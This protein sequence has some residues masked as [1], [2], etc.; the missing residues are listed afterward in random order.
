MN[1]AKNERRNIGRKKLQELIKLTLSVAVGVIIG[2]AIS[3]C[4][5]KKTEKFAREEK[6]EIKTEEKVTE[7]KSKSQEEKE[8]S[9]V[10][11]LHKGEVQKEVF[12]KSAT[13][14]AYPE[15]PTCYD[16]GFQPTFITKPEKYWN[17]NY[18]EFVF[19]PG[20]TFSCKILDYSI[21]CPAISS[22]IFVE[23]KEDGQKK[24]EVYFED[25]NCR[26]KIL[27]Y[28]FIVDT[29]PP[30]T[31]IV[32]VGFSE[33]ATAP[34]AMFEL[35]T[36]EPVKYTLCKVDDGFWFECSSSKFYLTSIEDG[37]HKIE[38]FS[39]DLAGNM[40]K[41]PAQLTFTVDAK[42]PITILLSA[43]PSITNTNYAEFIFTADEEEGIKFECNLNSAGWLPCDELFVISEAKQGIN[44]IEI[45]AIDRFGRYE[46]KPVKY[47]WQVVKGNIIGV[48]KPYS[49]SDE[50]LEL[51]KRKRGI[52]D[53]EKFIQNLKNR[54]TK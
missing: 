34:E 20:I 1:E 28:S 47:S 12:E 17:K 5:E 48:P 35:L 44:T 53:I 43:P 52:S 24:F 39:E 23:F 11:V 51:L 8:K 6:K 15:K 27:D 3:K 7:K 46:E 42:P 33:I 18:A 19:A 49:I 54:K 13:E 30:K 31:T 21:P 16:F 4:P 10:I 22:R 37:K 29:Y 14:L 45:R 41:P 32:P 38:A 50:F 9:K 40:E 2:I 26:R 25:G 36:S